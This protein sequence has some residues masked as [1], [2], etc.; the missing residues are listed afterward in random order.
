MMK[1]RLLP[2]EPVA[3]P[4]EKN[5]TSEFLENPAVR[6]PIALGTKAITSTLGQPGDIAQIADY[7]A[8]EGQKS[9]PEQPGKY[10]RPFNE[11]L[12]TAL[13]QITK[14]LAN[15]LPT[16][17]SLQQKAERY[18]PLNVQANYLEPQSYPEKLGHELVN[19]I[20]P[21]ALTKGLTKAA[22]SGLKA[23]AKA[24]VQTARTGLLPAVTGLAGKETARL[25]GFGP[26]GQTIAQ[27]GTS[28]L[29]GI[30]GNNK[31]IEDLV[32]QNYAQS[33][34]IGKGKYLDGSKLWNENEKLLDSLHGQPLEW[35]KVAAEQ[36]EAFKGA[37]QGMDRRMPVNEAVKRVQEFNK[38]GYDY[39]M[40]KEARD[41]FKQLAHHID[42][43]IV[44]YGKSNKAFG[45]PYELAKNGWRG[46]KEKSDVENFIM[47]YI[48]KGL[49]PLTE[50][51]FDLL[52]PASTY[53]LK[54]ATGG[55]L[56]AAAIAARR[57]DRVV[58]LFKHS[59][60][61]K[62]VWADAI[63]QASKQNIPGFLRD[64]N[65]FNKEA[66]KFDQANQ[67]KY[68]LVSEPEPE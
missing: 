31:A 63:K 36:L 16:Q 32:H 8:E 44:N 54:G 12:G 49:H 53:L 29:P 7:L 25:A 37:F 1:Y 10:G 14:P 67:M 19:I 39:K 52:V 47:Q 33:E 28:F 17:E 5:S 50:T 26:L 59:K 41:K 42:S 43:T 55:K 65:A 23:G 68:R 45:T 48:P 66:K 56:A 6:I 9:I 40:P 22:T 46:L 60:L 11:L 35:K 2:E 13:P 4:F 38:L 27:F 24:S 51:S 34:N 64:V 15:I 57:A 30:L 3:N 62:Q 20:A 21:G 58:R 61:A 18:I